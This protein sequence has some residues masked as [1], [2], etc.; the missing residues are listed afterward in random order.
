MIK[1]FSVCN[2]YSIS[3]RQYI[4]LSPD[5]ESQWDESQ[6]ITPA[7]N[8]LNTVATVIGHNASGKTNLL[9]AIAFCSW[10]MNHSYS[11]HTHDGVI[12]VCKHMLSES[13]TSKFELV[14]ECNNKEYKYKIH[15][16][17]K[18][19][20]YEWLG[21]VKNGKSSCIYE[22]RNEKGKISMPK[23]NLQKLNDED[24]NRFISLGNVS[25]YS[26]LLSTG[27][28][29]RHNLSEIAIFCPNLWSAG[30]KP[31]G[32][33]DNFLKLSKKLSEN[34]TRLET[35]AL[36]MQDFGLGIKRLEI[37]DLEITEFKAEDMPSVFKAKAISVVHEYKS[38]SFKLNL[39]GESNGTQ[40]AL[41]LLN[42]VLNVL[43]NGET[44]V[45]DEL[46]NSIH[47]AKKI[48]KLFAD[49]NINKNYAQLIFTTHHPWLLND[50]DKSQIFI[51]EKHKNLKSEIYR[52]D[53]VEGVKDSDNFCDKYLAGAYGGVAD[54]GWF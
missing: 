29:K 47:L 40:T 35:I 6:V 7:G 26:F 12:P 15:V 13:N 31:M 37:D 34:K 38:K 17:P 41:W 36:F 24:L 19:I 21:T 30:T 14:F 52:L 28:L 5:S 39:L 53:E 48:I 16:N 4:S 18:Y 2:F 46:E 51:V 54:I 25:L 20:E 50:R 42:N 1:F 9:K 32:S 11:Q 45:F 23:W 10:F 49:K 27:Y 8:R 44:L 43:E 33:I 22:M 3:N